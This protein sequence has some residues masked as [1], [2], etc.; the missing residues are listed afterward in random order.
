MPNT[1]EIDGIIY[2]DEPLK[3]DCIDWA[4]THLDCDT[5]IK[6]GDD[7][8]DPVEIICYASSEEYNSE[9]RKIFNEKYKNDG[10]IILQHISSLEVNTI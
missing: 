1:K 4:L 3:H 7:V 9:L 10:Y 2:F 5:I 8:D 6:D